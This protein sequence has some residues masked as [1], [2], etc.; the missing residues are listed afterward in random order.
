MHEM[1]RISKAHLPSVQTVFIISLTEVKSLIPYIT[2][3]DL[4]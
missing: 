1:H 3:L 2:K 4:S